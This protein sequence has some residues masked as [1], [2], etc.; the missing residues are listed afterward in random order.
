M[1]HDNIDCPF[2]TSN[3]WQAKSVMRVDNKIIW[4]GPE[5][6]KLFS[7]STQLSTEFI[8]L[9]NVKMPTID[10]I[11]TFTSMINTT[12][13]RLKARDFFLFA[14]LLVLMS[15]WNFMICWAEHIFI[16]SG[17]EHR[18]AKG[19]NTIRKANRLLFL[20][21]MIP[22]LKWHKE[23]SLHPIGNKPW[24]F[25]GYPGLFRHLYILPLYHISFNNI[26]CLHSSLILLGPFWGPGV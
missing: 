8:L 5:V 4:P 21:K 7:C 17:L 14:G 20:H 9:I 18:R 15:S 16:T 19:Q 1:K 26:F 2:N 24:A 3:R 22:K 10:G 11:L 6:I 12:S 23:L 25:M 13:E